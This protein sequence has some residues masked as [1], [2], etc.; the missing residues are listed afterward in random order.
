[1]ALEVSANPAAEIDDE[2][3]NAFR[4]SLGGSLLRPGDDGYDDARTIFNG[5]IDR[6]PGLIAP[7]S[8][9]PSRPGHGPVRVWPSRPRKARAMTP[10]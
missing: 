4:A 8:R 2:T 3:V 9:R 1:M 5:M 6:R 10:P 7:P